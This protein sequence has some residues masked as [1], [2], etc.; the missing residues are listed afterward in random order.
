MQR[1]CQCQA[2]H[3]TC[4][5]DLSVLDPATTSEASFANV[6]KTVKSRRCGMFLKPGI[7]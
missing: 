5:H 7:V 6:S 3:A 1:V 2:R 4:F